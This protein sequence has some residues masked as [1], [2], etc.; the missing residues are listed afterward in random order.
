MGAAQFQQRRNQTRNVERRA[1][2]DLHA[3]IAAPGRLAVVCALFVAGCVST[4]GS[5]LAPGR[6]T[7]ADVEATLGKPSETLAL[8]EGG[9]VAYYP[10]GRQTLAVTL[11]ADNRVRS[12]DQRLADEYFR[13]IAP[14]T[15]TMNEVRELLGPP[16]HSAR[17]ERRSRTVWEYRIARDYQRRQFI[18][19]FSDDGIVREVQNK[20][21]VTQAP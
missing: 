17:Y 21:E 12:V 4:T 15:T 20:P 5:N 2:I 11:G 9:R 7:S 19:D 1:L 6:S 3:I 14:G 16:D 10:R 18:V 13:R 8:A